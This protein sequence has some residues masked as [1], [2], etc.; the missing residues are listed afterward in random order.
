MDCH[1]VIHYVIQFFKTFTAEKIKE[2]HPYAMNPFLELGKT[3][4]FSFGH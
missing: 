2:A 1:G 4:Y 3:I